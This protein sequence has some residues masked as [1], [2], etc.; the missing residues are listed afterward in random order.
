MAKNI[1]KNTKTKK[2]KSKKTDTKRKKRS[3]DPVEIVKKLAEKLLE[4]MGSKAEVEVGLDKENEAVLVEIKT[5][6]EAG[7]LIGNRGDT[8]S[9][10]Q[11]I[12]GMMYRTRTNEWQ[13]ILVNVADWREKQET[14]L[15]NLAEQTAERTLASSEEQTLYNLNASQRRIVHMALSEVKGVETESAGEGKERH[16]VV[17]PKKSKKRRK[18]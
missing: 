15:Q 8:L 2:L 4:L 6:E 9:S 7:L 13:R 3:D 16:L 11:T 5:E 10:I 17:R 1:L 14:R 12:L 18:V